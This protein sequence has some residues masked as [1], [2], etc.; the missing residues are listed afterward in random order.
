MGHGP[1]RE[2]RL[3]DGRPLIVVTDLEAGY[4]GPVVGPVSFRVDRGEIVGL[5]GPNG[6][7]K[8]T[9]FNAI[10]GTARVLRG[11]IDRAPAT[12]ISVQRQHPVRLREMP[13]LGRELLRLTGA[14]DGRP[15]SGLVPL[16]DVRID[17]LSGGQFQL[18]QVWS[19]LGSASDLALLDEPGNN[20]DPA[21]LATL[22]ALLQDGD[23]RGVLV[24]SHDQRLLRR[25][26]TRL[27]DLAA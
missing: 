10:L 4:T 6:S 9:I 13:L 16:L 17:R 27:V 15:P 24:I 21:A 5:T 25:V 14:L 3:S 18:L 12:R 23:A 11:Q 26:C 2:G 7:G 22:E 19:A 8:T 1:R 20:M